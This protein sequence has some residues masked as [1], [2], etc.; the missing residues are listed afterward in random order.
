MK[1]RLLA[2]CFFSEGFWVRIFGYGPF[3]R[4][5]RTVLFGERY[6]YRK[7]CRF[8]RWSFEWLRP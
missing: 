2:S 7:V 4:R 5:D 8:G 6:G 3:I 1:Q